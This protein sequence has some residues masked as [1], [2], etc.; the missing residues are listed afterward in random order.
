MVEISFLFFFIFSPSFS[1]GEAMTHNICCFFSIWFFFF[2]NFVKEIY[3]SLYHLKS[4]GAVILFFSIVCF[5]PFAFTPCF[6][7]RLSPDLPF[8]HFWHVV[9]DRMRFTVDVLSELIHCKVFH[10]PSSFTLSRR[11]CR[12]NRP[13][14]F[15]IPISLLSNNPDDYSMKSTWTSAWLA[16]DLTEYHNWS[17][18]MSLQTFS[19]TSD[20][21]LINESSPQ[22]PLQKPIRL[23]L[24]LAKITDVLMSE[25]KR[26]LI[27][28]FPHSCSFNLMAVF[29]ALTKSSLSCL[30]C[31]LMYQTASVS[32]CFRYQV[33]ASSIP[34]H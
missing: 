3:S 13:F 34:L 24:L 20:E 15:S 32:A 29:V 14:V 28:K 7:S 30:V 10:H 2:S 12:R 31:V 6:A 5:G 4:V 1:F 19:W 33:S 9:F 22:L 25:R 8:F 18:A 11:L 26:S 17:S 27:R 23:S 16:K 21:E